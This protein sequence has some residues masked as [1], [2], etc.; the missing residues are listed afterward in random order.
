MAA[1][2]VFLKWWKPKTT[3]R[4]AGEQESVPP[5][6]K[7]RAQVRRRLRTAADRFLRLGRHFCC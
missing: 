4:F 7:R 2:A 3:F 5:Q 6:L 1:L